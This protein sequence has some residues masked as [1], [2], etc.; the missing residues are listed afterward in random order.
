MILYVSRLINSLIGSLGYVK[1]RRR[2]DYLGEEITSIRRGLEIE[3]TPE[4]ETHLFIESYSIFPSLFYLAG[5]VKREE[6]DARRG[7]YRKLRK[8]AERRRKEAARKAG[9]VYRPVITTAPAHRTQPL[10]HMMTKRRHSTPEG[11]EPASVISVQHP[12]RPQIVA[13]PREPYRG[14]MISAGSITTRSH[15]LR[16]LGQMPDITIEYRGN[17]H[18]MHARRTGSDE[19]TSI[20][21]SSKVDA[22]YVRKVFRTLGID[23]R[24]K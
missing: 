10:V 17:R 11:Q 24:L 9:S 20:A 3:Q 23:G 4:L 6:L 19:W 13:V 21:D 2:F 16:V 8:T 12:A 18:S 22:Y 7:E 15:L 14:R 1:Q 5:Y